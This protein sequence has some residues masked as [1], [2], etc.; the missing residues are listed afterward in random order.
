[1]PKKTLR[2]TCD[3]GALLHLLVKILGGEGV[4]VTALLY[5]CLVATVAA[6][7]VMVKTI[8]AALRTFSLRDRAVAPPLQA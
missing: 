5:S 2:A 4:C 1:M 7:G 6:V 8:V 3:G